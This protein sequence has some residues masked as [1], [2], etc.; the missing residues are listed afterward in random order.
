MAIRCWT[1]QADRSPRTSWRPSGTVK[2]ATTWVK[3]FGA[4]GLPSHHYQPRPGTCQ[5]RQVRGRWAG[6]LRGSAP[7]LSFG[8]RSGATRSI[9]RIRPTTSEP[10]SQ[11]RTPHRSRAICPAAKKSYL[12]YVTPSAARHGFLQQGGR[13]SGENVERHRPSWPRTGSRRTHCQGPPSLLECDPFL[14]LNGKVGVMRLCQTVGSN[15]DHFPVDM[16]E[17]SHLFLPC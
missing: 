17:L 13:P 7:G 3:V 6:G 4:A 15:A 16:D 10:D 14:T 9:P 8:P 11:G 5:P 12:R 2:G 1:S